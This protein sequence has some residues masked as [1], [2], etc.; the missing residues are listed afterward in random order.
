MSG[1]VYTACKTKQ[2][3]LLQ[4]GKKTG[5]GGRGWRAWPLNC[6]VEN[7]SHKSTEKTS[8]FLFIIEHLGCHKNFEYDNDTLKKELIFLKFLFV[9]CDGCLGQLYITGLILKMK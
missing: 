8:A 1:Y 3:H 5:E 4:K 9:M 2:R 6:E 7:P